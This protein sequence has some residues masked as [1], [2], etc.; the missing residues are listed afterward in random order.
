[1]KDTISLHPTIEAILDY[2]LEELHRDHLCELLH[3]HHET[4]AGLL[5]SGSI[6]NTAADLRT[7]RVH[8]NYSRRH[9]T[10]AALIA[11]LWDAHAGDKTLIRELL[12]ARAPA[13]LRAL[14]KRDAAKAS[15]SGGDLPDNVTPHPLMERQH[16]AA[17]RRAQAEAAAKAQTLFP[18]FITTTATAD[19]T[20]QSA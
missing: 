9:T 7:G 20:K 13:L 6:G 5:K 12:T 3:C 4:A 11:F 15:G 1:M 8:G 10:K 2:P 14:E 19:T 17:L 18:F 16:R